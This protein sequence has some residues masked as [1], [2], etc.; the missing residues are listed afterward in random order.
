MTTTWWNFLRYFSPYV[1]PLF[2][3]AKCPSLNIWNPQWNKRNSI[4]WKLPN[5]QT[6]KGNI[7]KAK[8]NWKIKRKSF[9]TLFIQFFSSI[10]NIRLEHLNILCYVCIVQDLLQNLSKHTKE[11]QTNK[12][13]QICLYT[14]WFFYMY[15][16]EGKANGHVWL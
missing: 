2:I 5:P 15:R 12:Q 1:D 11:K 8:W 4:N 10:V 16:V 3:L 13:T 14:I 6:Y 9:P 7:V